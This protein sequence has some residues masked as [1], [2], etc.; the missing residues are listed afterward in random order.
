MSKD[1]SFKVVMLGD[2][3]VGKTCLVNRFIKQSYFESEPTLAQDFK[4][5]VVQ[6]SIDGKN[7]PVRLQIWDTAGGEQYRSLAPIYFKGAQA[8]CLVY[9]STADN[10]L[11]ALKYW[12]SQ[13]KEVVN[14]KFATFV[15]AAKIDLSER[16]KVSIKEAGEFA[17][18][19]GA[20][21]Y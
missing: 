11:E 20:E 18:L 12:F 5:K 16:E 6:V 1:L 21:L 10:A 15:I 7:V 3:S 14:T 2:S 8:F 19:C 4:S 17:K 13:I 9:D